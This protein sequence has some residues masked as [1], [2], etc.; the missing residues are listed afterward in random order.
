MKLSVMPFAKKWA[1]E[2]LGDAASSS[3]IA[4]EDE[5]LAV[6]GAMTLW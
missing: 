5:Y 3:G 6:M 2:T 1:T 4:L